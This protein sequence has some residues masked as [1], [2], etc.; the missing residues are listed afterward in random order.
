MLLA[1][2]AALLLGA[3]EPADV[4]TDG[5]PPGMVAFFTGA[6]C[7]DGWKPADMVAGRVVIAVN[8]PLAVGRT[9]GAPLAPAEDRVHGHDVTGS[10]A[11]P[12]KLLAAG[13]GN[14]NEDGAAAGTRTFAGTAAAA[15][16]GLPFVQLTACVRP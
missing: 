11:L 6:A 3:H 1:G 7:P 14:Y 9:V 5:T 10:V 8:D 13:D 16:T 4:A 2:S 12:S 15:P